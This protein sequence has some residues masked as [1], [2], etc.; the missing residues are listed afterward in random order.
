LQLLKKGEQHVP[1]IL[2]STNTAGWGPLGPLR[3]EM[4]RLL[5]SLQA[6]FDCWESADDTPVVVK[7]DRP[8][9]QHH[10][11]RI[12]LKSFAAYSEAAFRSVGF[13]GKVV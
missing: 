5:V 11:F 3:G 4:K 12:G 6:R 1:S 7:V 8:E 9:K 13:S 2:A 10:A